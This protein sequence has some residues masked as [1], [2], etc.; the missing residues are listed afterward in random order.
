MIADSDYDIAVGQ[1]GI[2]HAKF[3][4]KGKAAHGSQPEKGVN[5]IVKATTFINKLNELQSNLKTN[6]DSTLGYGTLNVGKIAGGT[7]V[8]IVADRC[9]VEIDRRLTWGET[10]SSALNQF[11]DVLRRLKLDAEVRLLNEPRLAVKTST[12]SKLVE[13]LRGIDSKLK[14]GAKA[15]YTEMELYIRELGMECVACGPI[16]EGQAHANDE[17]VKISSIKKT[18]KLY[19]ELIKKWCC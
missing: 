12:N 5:A 2:L 18:T 7:K 1:K 19:T 11:K 4:F 13:I 15:G 10:S 9:E 6:K 14:V 3:V 16:E 8:N 17:F